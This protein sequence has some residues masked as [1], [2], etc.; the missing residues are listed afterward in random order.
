MAK[1]GTKIVKVKADYGGLFNKKYTY[2][3][4]DADDNLVTDLDE[5]KKYM[6]DNSVLGENFYNHG[7]KVFID[8][9]SPGNKNMY[10]VGKSFYDD[11]HVLM[12]TP[13]EQRSSIVRFKTFPRG[14][15]TNVYQFF[16]ENDEYIYDE[17]E[18]SKFIA[19]TEEINVDDGGLYYWDNNYRQSIL[20]QE[21]YDSY[22]SGFDKGSSSN[23]KSAAVSST[24]SS[25]DSSTTSSAS[26]SS[27]ASIENNGKFTIPNINGDGT[28]EVSINE[29]EAN[30][31]GTYSG[32]IKNADGNVTDYKITP[33]ENT[34]EFAVHAP[35]N[36]KPTSEYKY[37]N[38]GDDEVSWKITE[39]TDF[40]YDK[41]G[42]PVS[43]EIVTYERDENGTILSSTESYASYDEES[44]TYGEPQKQKEVKYIYDDKNNN[45]EVIEKTY[46]DGK[47][48]EE[49]HKNSSGDETEKH[50]FEYEDGK[51]T[52]EHV[53]NKK[54]GIVADRTYDAT[55]SFVTDE[56]RT[57]S[58]GRVEHSVFDKHDSSNR[59]LHEM[60]F[61]SS[62][63]L[64]NTRVYEY[65]TSD[66]GWTVTEYDGTEESY[67]KKSVYKYDSHGNLVGS[68]FYDKDG[69]E[70]LAGGGIGGGGTTPPASSGGS[71]DTQAYAEFKVELIN[72][73]S[74]S[75]NDEFSKRLLYAAFID[76]DNASRFDTFYNETRKDASEIKTSVE[77]VANRVATSN[78]G[79]FNDTNETKI[80]TTTSQD[81]DT[82][83]ND[84]K[85][86]NSDA[87]R[88]TVTTYNT[89]FKEAKEMTRN[90]LAERVV[91]EIDEQNNG[92]GA[93]EKMIEEKS[94]DWTTEPPPASDVVIET[95]NKYYKVYRFIEDLDTQTKTEP[96]NP[97]NPDEGNHE[98]TYYKY[99]ER[100][101]RYDYVFT[102]SGGWGLL[103]N[104]IIA[105]N[106]NDFLEAKYV[107][108]SCKM[109]M[110]D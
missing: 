94:Q 33:K 35:G 70:I 32:T 106:C 86:P 13:I 25:T 42:N 58:D 72:N 44:E 53:E 49:V 52:K 56:T 59:P 69:K 23:G 20:N 10:S 51:L 74:V 26:S 62:N 109:T 27:K 3:F 91:K 90:H 47:V 99:N 81:A 75:D 66:G 68:N 63:N 100:H 89:N 34:V 38:Y 98:V 79:R 87:F 18:I 8:L 9:S 104:E 105:A 60:V 57:Y 73:F 78:S 1:D 71:T 39:K 4:Y 2:R 97:E 82:Y 64:L 85:D 45:T 108:G 36:S 93:H 95:D 103:E 16:G 54:D 80:L 7:D 6:A 88:K 102:K 50:T 107:P 11:V 37:V 28:I 31:D 83:T 67:T 5:I 61:D 65:N 29:L 55:G 30:K 41:D 110:G 77:D 22:V 15:G 43:K 21:E 12:G 92:R 46:E 19:Q 84:S 14:D 17:E 76:E 96:I 40:E 48:K 24:G 101:R